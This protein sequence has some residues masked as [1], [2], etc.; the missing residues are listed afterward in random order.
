[1]QHEQLTLTNISFGEFYFIFDHLNHFFN[2][3]QVN[4]VFNCFDLGRVC[5]MDEKLQLKHFLGSNKHNITYII[6]HFHRLVNEV[7]PF[8]DFDT[9]ATLLRSPLHMHIYL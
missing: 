2:L 4:V 9:I 1:M 8:F 5:V 6:S 3:S 7:H